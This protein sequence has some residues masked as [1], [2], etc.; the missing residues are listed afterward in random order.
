M[1]E[2]EQK[3]REMLAAFEAGSVTLA[4]GAD[5]TKALAQALLLLAALCDALAA[6]KQRADEAKRR[7]DLAKMDA[8]QWSTGMTNQ[9]VGMR[10]MARDR[11]EARRE[12]EALR[13]EVD[14]LRPFEAAE[15]QRRAICAMMNGGEQ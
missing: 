1:S 9:N 12:V 7:A 8:E 13:A 3:A 10:V 15:M 6:E 11:D 4:D 5:A 14:R 2:A